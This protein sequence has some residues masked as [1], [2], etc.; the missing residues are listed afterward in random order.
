VPKI[1]ALHYRKLVRVFEQDGFTVARQEGSHIVLTKQGI[2]RPVV[3]PTYD[4]IPVF[5][6]KNCL[7]TARMSR[8]RYFELLENM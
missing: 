4:E 5:I 3:I 6:I 1:V 7:R 2:L 8:D